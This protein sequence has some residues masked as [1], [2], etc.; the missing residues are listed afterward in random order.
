MSPLSLFLS[1]PP[2]ATRDRGPCTHHALGKSRPVTSRFERRRSD[3]A[4]AALSVPASLCWREERGHKRQK[5]VKI[6]KKRRATSQFYV[7]SASRVHASLSFSRFLSLH[8][9]PT[10]MPAALDAPYDVEANSLGREKVVA[11]EHAD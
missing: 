11:V 5:A 7:N 8:K 6:E 1:P 10:P 2:N 4:L 3:A 9:S